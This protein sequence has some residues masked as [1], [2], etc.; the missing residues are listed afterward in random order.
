M[1]YLVS[2]VTDE[3]VLARSISSGA[4]LQHV[5]AYI[6]DASAWVKHEEL[7][8]LSLLL[9]LLPHLC[10]CGISFYRDNGSAIAF[11]RRP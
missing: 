7:E 1:K 8:L 11:L 9:C 3:G 2:K 6:S 4:S 10:S 5:S